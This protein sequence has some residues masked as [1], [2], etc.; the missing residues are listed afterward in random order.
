MRRDKQTSEKSMYDLILLGWSTVD[1]NAN[2]CKSE[3]N[4]TID[5]RARQVEIDLIL[6]MEIFWRNPI[7][8][9]FQLMSHYDVWLL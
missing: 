7:T 2:L 4:F 6:N 1:V 3:W 8:E 9:L 5:V